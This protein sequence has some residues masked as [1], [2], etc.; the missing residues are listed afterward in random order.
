MKQL[1]TFVLLL[2]LG[3]SCKT[4]ALY[5][6]LDS[7]DTVNIVRK[8]YKF[9]KKPV[10][11]CKNYNLDYLILKDDPEKFYG[12]CIDL[13]FCPYTKEYLKTLTKHTDWGDYKISRKEWKHLI[14]KKNVKVVDGVKWVT[15]TH[16]DALYKVLDKYI[17]GN[18]YVVDKRY[19]TKDSVRV[20]GI[21]LL[22]VRAIFCD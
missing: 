10:S 8:V 18:I 13:Q 6:T 16:W 15:K 7:R 2:F 22:D 1:I 4:P 19:A 5:I 20:M 11:Y 9:R 12:G 3:I 17:H 21:M 14:K